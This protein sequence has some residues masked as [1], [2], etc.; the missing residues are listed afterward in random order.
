[1]L[2]LLGGEVHEC[3]EGYGY[4]GGAQAEYFSNLWI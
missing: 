4:E 3:K 1:M 2:C